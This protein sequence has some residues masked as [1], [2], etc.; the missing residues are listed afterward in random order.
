[1][2]EKLTKTRRIFLGAV[3]GFVLAGGLVQAIDNH[4]RNMGRFSTQ[5]DLIGSSQGVKQLV[6]VQGPTV[7]AEQL[8]LMQPHVSL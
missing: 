3:A 7:V 1:M 8:S 4:A 6:R 5:L 2:I